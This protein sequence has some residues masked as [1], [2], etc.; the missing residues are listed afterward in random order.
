[1]EVSDKLHGPATSHRRN[2]P[3][4]YFRGGWVSG[5]VDFHAAIFGNRF[6]AVWPVDRSIATEISF[7]PHPH[8]LIVYARDI[9]KVTYVYFRQFCRSGV[10][11]VNSR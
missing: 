3:V 9:R 11:L 1:L 8:F 5:S 7:L 2:S 6:W 4:T 10:E